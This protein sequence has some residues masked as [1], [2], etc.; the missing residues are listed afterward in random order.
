MDCSKFQELMSDYLDGQLQPA[1]SRAVA[2]HSLQCRACRA[3]MDEVKAALGECCARPDAAPSAELEAALLMIPAEHRRLGC[4]DFEE[5]ITEFLDGFVHA[6]TYQRFE[7]HAAACSDCSRLL[8]DVVYA[9]AACHSVHTYEEYEAPEALVCRL[10]E[11][12]PERRATGGRALADAV[13]AF[14]SQLMPRATHRTGWSFATASGL[15]FATFTLLLFGFSEDQTL[16]GIY[17][18]ALVKAA[19]VYS[20]GADLYAQKDEVVAELEKVG[21]D[22]GEIWDTLGG[23]ESGQRQPPDKK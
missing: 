15:V 12:M 6:C 11:I 17:R 20:Q 5:V 18:R 10:I 21:S 4:A 13:V 19:E 23:D 7:A 8:T 9:V 22:I 1:E 3:V 2:E 14:A 16:A